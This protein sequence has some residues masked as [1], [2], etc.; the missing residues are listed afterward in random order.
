MVE[1]T[2]SK[3][4]LLGVLVPMPTPG[5]VWAFTVAR[6]APASPT[7]SSKRRKAG[8]KWGLVFGKKTGVLE[9]FYGFTKDVL[10]PTRRYGMKMLGPDAGPPGEEQGA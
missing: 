5:V 9:Y 7:R 3:A 6:E 8:E 4:E 1:L 10:T 2:S